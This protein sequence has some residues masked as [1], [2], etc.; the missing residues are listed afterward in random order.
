MGVLYFGQDL[1]SPSH[2]WMR[3]ML[4]ALADEVSVLVSDVDPGSEYRGQFRC[5]DL[6]SPDRS[7]PRRVL[8]RL[9]LMKYPDP[10]IVAL[11]RFTAAVA[12]ADVSVALV[13]FLNYAVRFEAAWAESQKPIF[14]HCHGYDVTWDLRD[15][16][17]QPMHP[18]GYVEQVKKLSRRVHLIANSEA[19]A[20]RLRD[21]G[22]ASDRITVKYLGV[23]VPETPPQRRREARPLQLLYLARLVDCKGPDLTIRAFE[24]AC[25]RGL[26]GVLTLAGGGPLATTCRLLQSRSRHADRIHLLGPVTAA[27]GEVLR[28]ETDLFVAHNCLGPITRQEEAFGVA[29]VEAMAAGLPVVSG[30]NGSLPEVMDDGV[31]GILV[32]PGDVEAHANAFLRLAGDSDLRL[33]MGH[34]AWERAGARFRIGTERA[35]LRRILMLP[36]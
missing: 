5:V 3:R 4:T 34:A 2:L 1:N 9:K 21:I 15:H 29:F 23:D 22:I 8:R 24:I 35:A 13:H 33:R 20:R 10:E 16:D 7:I 31:H 25:D 14:V 6:L 17:G 30:R 12:A 11:R 28:G 26:D 27:Q 36:P 19:A 18:E 32:E